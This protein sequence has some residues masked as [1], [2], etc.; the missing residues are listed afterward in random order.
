MR[1]ERLLRVPRADRTIHLVIN[2]PEPAAPSG[3]VSPSPKPTIRARTLG[4]LK[5]AGPASVATAAIILSILSLQQQNSANREQ[6]QASAAA[7]AATERLAA[8]RV[9]FLQDFL[10]KPPFTSLVVE[11]LAATPAHDVEFQ[12]EA[13]VNTGAKSRITKEFILKLGSIPACSSGAVNI[14]PA[15]IKLMQ[16]TNGLRASRIRADAVGINVNSMD[17]VDSNGLGWQYF[18]QGG[19]EQVTFISLPG[20][21]PISLGS[22]QATYKTAP[23]CA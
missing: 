21:G 15:V 5:I 19:L 14:V 11:N 18:G 8:E 22:V 20:S 10:P 16:G 3:S 17:F 6:R 4:V 12:A 2:I 13:T 9:S 23:G 7:A 1:L